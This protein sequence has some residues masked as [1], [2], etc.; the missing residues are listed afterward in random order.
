M[1]ALMRT[2]ADVTST[3]VMSKGWKSCSIII[4]SIEASVILKE[5]WLKVS[6]LPVTT[7][8]NETIAKPLGTGGDNGESDSGDALVGGVPGR[9]GAALFDGADGGG[10]G[11]GGEGLGG[12]G[13]GGDGSGDGGVDGCGDRGG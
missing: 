8:T 7:T 4:D 1:V 11:S 13:G 5:L 9:R 3:I 2:L 6:M 10:D 12:G